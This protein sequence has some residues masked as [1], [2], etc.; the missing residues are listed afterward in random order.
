MTP[1]E[2]QQTIDAEKAAIEKLL[3]ERDFIE[4]VGGD[5]EAKRRWFIRQREKAVA[6]LA[7]VEAHIAKLF[8]ENK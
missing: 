5:M 2:I 7:K 1:A 6:H 4:A 8:P 3:E